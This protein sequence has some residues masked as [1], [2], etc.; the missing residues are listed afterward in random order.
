LNHGF[1]RADVVL[2][3]TNECVLRALPSVREAGVE[4]VAEGRVETRLPTEIRLP[5]MAFRTRERHRRLYRG[6]PGPRLGL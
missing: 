3:L 6:F 5:D 4:S 2:R 1:H